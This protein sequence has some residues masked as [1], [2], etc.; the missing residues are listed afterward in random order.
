MFKSALI[1][2]LRRAPRE[3][4]IAGAVM[5][6]VA[7]MGSFESILLALQIPSGLLASIFLGAP[8]VVE[9]QVVRI[10]TQPLLTVNAAC[11]G[12]RFFAF[13]A[14]LGGGYWCGKR[15]GRWLV[16]LPLCYLITLL[17]NA[18]RI[19][20]AWQF[21]RFTDGRIPEWLQEYTHMGIGI[22]CF[23]SLSAAL[24]YWTHRQTRK[25]ITHETIR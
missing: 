14:G 7:R 18:A 13:I 5:L 10:F 1:S 19:S 20:M 24:L 2:S 22:V 8:A 16:L 6:L 11:S 3:P 15:V 4:L 17:G 9:D 23:L 21:R 25:E 12:V